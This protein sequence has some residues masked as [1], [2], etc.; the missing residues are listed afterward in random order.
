VWTSR[1]KGI[2]VGA[3][4]AVFAAKKRTHASRALSVQN[5]PL[6]L[7]IINIMS[8]IYD[9]NTTIQSLFGKRVAQ[10]N[11]SEGGELLFSEA[12]RLP[13]ILATRNP[14]LSLQAG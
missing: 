11:V 4:V 13:V 8:I 1:G 3:A 9:C 2:R 12:Y 7:L 10:R 5:G 6:F 14:I